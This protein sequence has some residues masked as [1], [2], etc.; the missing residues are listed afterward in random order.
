MFLQNLLEAKVIRKLVFWSVF[1]IL[2]CGVKG[3]PMPPD[4][5]PTIG[6]GEPAYK[7]ATE[8]IVLPDLPPIILDS[9]QDD[10]EAV[11]DE[12]E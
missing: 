7:E 6:R 1:F 2:G 10:E 11:T 12:D 9:N 4:K 8:D 3:D 5:P